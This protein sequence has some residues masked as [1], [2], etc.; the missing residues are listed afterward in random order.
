M[1]NLVKVECAF[2]KNF[3]RLDFDRKTVMKGL[4]K[5]SRVVANQSKKLVAPKRRS[6]PGEYPGRDT[7]RMRRNIKVVSAKKR[8]HF[9]TRVQ[10]SSFKD[11]HFFYPAVLA[12]GKKNRTL[13]P[14]RNFIADAQTQ[15]I[16]QTEPVINQAV[17]DALK[18]W[19]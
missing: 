18:V 19:G 6:K 9:W 1:A 13:L 10:V 5:A 11:K 3:T 8:E 12:A 7:G 16:H 4:R 14:R 15:T 17:W 2:P